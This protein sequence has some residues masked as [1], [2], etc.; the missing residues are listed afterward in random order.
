MNCNVR[1]N[2]FISTENDVG[3]LFLLEKKNKIRNITNTRFCR[4]GACTFLLN[5][6]H[7]LIFGFYYD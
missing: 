2:I 3:K 6:W 4:L 7:N 5:K 1:I